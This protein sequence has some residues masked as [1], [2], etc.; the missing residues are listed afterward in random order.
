MTGS[1][2]AMMIVIC[3]LVWGGFVIF[4]SIVWKIEKRKRSQKD[5]E[6]QQNM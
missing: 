1:A 2:V 5:S 3:T 4:L 6:P